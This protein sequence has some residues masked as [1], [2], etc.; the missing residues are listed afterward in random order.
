MTV[1]LVLLLKDQPLGELMLPFLVDSNN[2]NATLAVDSKDLD[3]TGQ[4]MNM[5]AVDVEQLV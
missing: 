5:W 2:L 1:D 4:S 3:A